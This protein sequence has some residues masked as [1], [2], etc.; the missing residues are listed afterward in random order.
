MKVWLCLT[1]AVL[2][3]GCSGKEI[4]DS[5]VSMIESEVAHAPAPPAECTVRAD[6][7]WKEAPEGDERADAVARRE[8]ANKN[9]FAEL[10]QS[11][12][13]CSAG[14]VAVNEPKSK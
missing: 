1:L 8:R 11:R 13:I 6:P 10:A 12:R 5:W 4:P 7:R 3:A 2:L 14:L 9:A